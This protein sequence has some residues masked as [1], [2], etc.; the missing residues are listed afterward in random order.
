MP[1]RNSEWDAYRMKRRSEPIP[2]EEPDTPP[3]E[4]YSPAVVWAFPLDAQPGERG[5]Q[6]AAPQ[7]PPQPEG[8]TG[9]SGS[10]RPLTLLGIAGMTVLVALTAALAVA[11]LAGGSSDKRPEV[12]RQ[13]PPAGTS[14]TPPPSSAAPSIIGPGCGGG[15]YKRFGYYVDGKAGWLSG[16]GG[17]AGAGCNGSFDALPM[18]GD[19][20]KADPT[21]YAQWEFDPRLR[22]KCKVLLY[23]PDNTDR[24]YVGGSPARYTVGQRNGDKKLLSF[25]IDQPKSL[26]KWVD[27]AV[28]NVDG[29]F[30]V[31]LANTGKDWTDA[32]S[33]FTH[34]VAAQARAICS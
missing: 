7:A 23:I 9:P 27:S 6:P 30:H 14:T 2:P 15:A 33:T 12:T 24:R 5:V 13:P 21:L 1:D 20:K 17:Y 28:F 10:K 26:G 19:A 18:S 25:S 4:A 29:P 34:V 22:R 11:F 32:R 3:A 8:P 31:R 16:S